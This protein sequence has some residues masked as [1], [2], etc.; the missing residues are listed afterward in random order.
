[1]YGIIPMHPVLALHHW[2]SAQCIVAAASSA[3]SRQAQV[4]CQSAD[5][6][7]MR[8]NSCTVSASGSCGVCR[9]K[10]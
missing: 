10:R 1:M 2:V 6:L 3:S 5:A 8:V 9:S 7:C 4:A